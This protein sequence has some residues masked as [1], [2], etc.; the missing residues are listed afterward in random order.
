MDPH[1][2][3]WPPRWLLS[4]LSP[5]CEQGIVPFHAIG[6]AQA[7]DH[8]RRSGVAYRPLWPTFA[9]VEVL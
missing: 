6:R 8:L 4:A 9:Y 7:V 2:S 1:P 3:A 5:G